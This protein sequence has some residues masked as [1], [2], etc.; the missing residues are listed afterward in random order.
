MNTEK[1]LDEVLPKQENLTYAVVTIIEN[2]LKNNNIDYLTVT[3]RTKDRESV[4]DKIKRKGY[5]KPKEQLTDISGIRIIVFFESSVKKVSKLIEASFEVDK[6]NSLNKD[7]LLSNDQIGYRSVHYVCT[8]GETRISLPEF[9]YL[10]GLKF[11]FQIRTVLQ[12]AWAEIAHDRNYK[13]SGALPKEI[14]R[15]LYLYAGLLEVADK[16]FDELSKSIDSYM[17]NLHEKSSHGDLEVEINSISLEQFVSKWSKNNNFALEGVYDKSNLSE[18]VREL[19]EFGINS[20]S[21]LNAIIP[22][23]YVEIM[24]ENKLSTNIYG[25]IRD[26]MLISD[27]NKFT[28][29]VDYSWSMDPLRESVLPHIMPEDEFDALYNKFEWEDEDAGEYPF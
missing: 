8:L 17:E 19:S 12:H 3:G 15:N 5:K 25:L 24:K 23:N 6:K 21:E 14:E 10:S 29:N 20:L 27:H 28:E 11:E 1:W 22:E 26:W 13:F 2:L 16:G 18:L 4:K 9:E 7:A